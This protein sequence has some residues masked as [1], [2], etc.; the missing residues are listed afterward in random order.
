MA[1]TDRRKPE[2]LFRFRPA[3][4]NGLRTSPFVAHDAESIIGRAK[5][6]MW[7]SAY[8]NAKF[9][10]FGIEDE[11][12]RV[13]FVEARGPDA[14]TWTLLRGRFLVA[15]L[16]AGFSPEVW[17]RL[18]AGAAEMIAQGRLLAEEMADKA[19]LGEGE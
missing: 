5:G 16:L 19:R 11:A 15:D 10:E 7:Q 14:G 2:P 18:F 13:L 9:K 4:E 8:N 12:A 6:H 3:D 17:E 1:T